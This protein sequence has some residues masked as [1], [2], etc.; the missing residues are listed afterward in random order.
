MNNR[1][2]ELE[3]LVKEETY[4]KTPSNFGLV[5]AFIGYNLIALVI[6][7]VSAILVG[8]VTKFWL[9]GLLVMSAGALPLIVHEV[10]W[11]RAYATHD[12]RR[13]AIFGI[14]LAVISVVV[15]AIAAGVAYSMNLA[16]TIAPVWMDVGIIVFLISCASAHG[17]IFAWYYFTDEEFIANSATARAI[18]RSN[19]KIAK[20]QA[21][22]RI[23][24]HAQ[25][26]GDH[27]R[28]LISDFEGNQDAVD[29]ALRQVSGA[30]VEFKSPP[31]P[32]RIGVR[33]PKIRQ[34]SFSD[35]HRDD[36]DP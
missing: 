20:V 9:Y 18:S 13:L 15:M 22:R 1:V 24:E 34:Q 29:E 19:R 23:L 36:D 6:D 16:N 30:N 21:A 7:I 35:D 33:P 10:L 4:T 14:V 12:Q 31:S 5:I 8:T 11:M 27:R 3:S 2:N 32:I 26:Y 25:V 17:L 28:D